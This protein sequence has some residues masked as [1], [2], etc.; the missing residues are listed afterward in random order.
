MLPDLRQVGNLDIYLEKI[1]ST[2]LTQKQLET[3]TKEEHLENLIQH[4]P[5]IWKKIF[6]KTVQEQGIEGM[7]S[8]SEVG[9]Q[10]NDILENKSVVKF[11]QIL[12]ILFFT[13]DSTSSLEEE[14]GEED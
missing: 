11:T 14:A 7:I 5:L 12:L 8:A 13:M 4:I 3:A 6:L 2:G 1:L 10:L 9:E